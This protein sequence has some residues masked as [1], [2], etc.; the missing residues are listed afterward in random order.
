MSNVKVKYCGETLTTLNDTGII[1]LNTDGKLLTDKVEIDFTDIFTWMGKDP[2][3]VQS[4]AKETTK[5]SD[6]DY[7]GWTP[8]TTAQVIKASTNLGTQVLDMVNYDYLIMWRFYVVPSYNGSQ[9]NVSR[10]IK[11]T[12]TIIQMC[13]RRPSNLTNL[14]NGV[15]NGNATL[16]PFNYGVAE[17][18]NG[19]GSHTVQW[20]PAYG[21]YASVVSATFSSST[22]N[23]PT[24]TIKRPTFNARCN[25]SY[26]STGNA[27]AIDQANTNLIL[28]CDLYRVKAGTCNSFNVYNSIIDS[29]RNGL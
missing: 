19:S 24:L 22:S 7:N 4:Y 1:K 14:N 21:L 13:F 27:S 18:Y 6:T 2:E 8:S 16:N 20:N 25:G 10:L 26:L 28:K 23:T 11:S 15:R 29:F 12:Q 17:V 3:L 9:T 5:L